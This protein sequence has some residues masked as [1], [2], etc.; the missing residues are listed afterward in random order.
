MYVKKTDKNR[1]GV[2]WPKYKRE[3][4][5]LISFWYFNNWNMRNHPVRL[6]HGYKVESKTKT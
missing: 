1:R 4:K 5:G 2:V 6:P 3:K